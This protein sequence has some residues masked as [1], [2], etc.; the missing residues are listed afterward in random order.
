MAIFPSRL[1]TLL[2]ILLGACP[3]WAQSHPAGWFQGSKPETVIMGGDPPITFHDVANHVRLVEFILGF[4]A[5]TA[6]KAGFLQ[7]VRSAAKAGKAA[8]RDH[9][10]QARELVQSM[11]TMGDR[12]RDTIR[13]LLLE[14]FRETAKGDQNDPAAR[15]FLDLQEKSGTP[16]L[17]TGPAM[18]SRLALEAFCE[19]LG[20]ALN[21]AAP[22]VLAPAQQAEVRKVLTAA[23]AKAPPAAT[24]G[25]RGFDRA[26]FAMR[27]IASRDPAAREKL[28]GSLRRAVGSAGKESR[29][30]SPKLIEAL[31]LPALWQETASAAVALGEP[32]PGWPADLKNI[33]W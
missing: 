27:V 15:L 22:V 4:R 31:L 17:G 7:A 30:S 20:F 29:P 8:A 14:D 23:L 25:L 11:G 19:Y 28:T 18:V 26:W 12:E 32:D 24:T 6:Q 9:L 21:P 5:T 16:A 10:L 1:L 2:L 33:V 13:G 3:G